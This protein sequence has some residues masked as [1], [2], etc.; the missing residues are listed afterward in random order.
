MI[1]FLALGGRSLMDQRL[2]PD[3]PDTLSEDLHRGGASDPGSR[4][5]HHRPRRAPRPSAY[6]ATRC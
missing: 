2:D 5:G 3:D 1:L 4:H 6:D